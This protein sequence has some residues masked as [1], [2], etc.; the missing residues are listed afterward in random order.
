[1]L[2][3]FKMQ[4]II[5]LVS[6]GLCFSNLHSQ[7]VDSKISGSAF[8]SAYDVNGKAFTAKL[9]ENVEGSPMF[10][11]DWNLAN[12]TLQ[13]GKVAK[14]VP[15]QFN[16]NDNQLYFKKD[17]IILVF[18]DPVASFEF[19]YSDN[20]VKRLA[21]FSNGYPAIQKNTEETYYQVLANGPMQLLK[22]AYKKP[23]QIAEYNQTSKYE[24]QLW[25]EL[26]AYNTSTKKIVKI[27]DKLS[28]TSSF[29]AYAN[30]INDYAAQKNSKL[31][32]E[33]ELIDLFNALNQ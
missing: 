14:D 27:K 18:V 19:A 2:S 6:L 7:S 8:V 10:S 30:A 3:N 21:H 1:M 26:Y 17:D 32:T 24:Y 16:L 25:K 22:Y 4:K 9:L 23:A 33:A 28:L 20:G 31:K 15:V 5:I 11:P 29:P 12:V 13:N